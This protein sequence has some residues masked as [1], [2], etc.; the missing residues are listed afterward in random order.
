MSTDTLT[1][2]F[3]P[4]LYNFHDREAIIFRTGFRSVHISYLDLY[5]HAYR[6]ANWYQHNGLEKGDAMLIWAPNS[7]EWVAAL[8]ACSL[9]GVIAVPL[10]MK[11]QPDFVRH[12]AAET[13]A[14]AGIKSK[15]MGIKS[16]FQ[17]WDTEDLPR[18][19]RQAPPI[20]KEPEI[21]GDDVL[22]IVYTSGTTAA[23]KGVVLTNR[24][25]VSN[26]ASLSKVLS[27]KKEWRF[28]SLL[29]L[30]HMFE[31]TVGL[32]VPLFYGCSITYLRTRKSAAILQAM[33]DEGITSIITVPLMLQTLRERI[34]R[35][36]SARGK[37]KVFHRMLVTA[38][39][40]PRWVRKL[41]FRS[42]HSKFGGRLQF[43][44]VGGAHL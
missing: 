15:F 11:V 37:E 12:I 25:I 17:W 30:S 23:P 3:K 39:S 20:F 26:I 31:Q 22:E 24:N 6:M 8:L 32:F 40:L 7:P 1:N 27:Y 13:G 10:D 35:E 33:Q 28:L 43:F 5:D 4:I 21:H 44:A 29:P 18:L 19:I 34:L 2:Y 38:K 41:L 42:A 36:V 14:K 9:T 16:D